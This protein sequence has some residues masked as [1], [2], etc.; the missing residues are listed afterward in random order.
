[1]NDSLGLVLAIL[2]VTVIISCVTGEMG[3]WFF[4]IFG[5][6]VGLMAVSAIGQ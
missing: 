5:I 3:L 1:M 4:V 2:G 6:T